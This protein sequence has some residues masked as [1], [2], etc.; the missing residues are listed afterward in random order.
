MKC[1]LQ[2]IFAYSTLAICTFAACFIFYWQFLQSTD[3]LANV[4][5]PVTIDSTV[6][7]GSTMVLRRKICI[8]NNQYIGEVSRSFT[9]HVIYQLPD[10]SSSYLNSKLG[11]IEKKYIIDIPSVLPSGDYDYKVVISF[12]INP[13][14]TVH[15]NLTT[16]KLKVVNSVWDK[17][18]ELVEEDK[19]KK[20]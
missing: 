6:E 14:K 9:N 10:T 19:E 15:F 1:V 12:K 7:A 3:I 20:Q 11:C 8:N 5:Q 13:I 18:K 16:V 17:V 4:D 2:A